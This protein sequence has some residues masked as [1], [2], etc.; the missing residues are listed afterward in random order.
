MW[1]TQW[2]RSFVVESRDWFGDLSAREARFIAACLKGGEGMNASHVATGGITA[3]LATV[4]VYLSHWPPQPLDLSTA[5]AFAGLLV[6]AGAGLVKLYKS[7]TAPTG[8]LVVP[9]PPM[10]SAAP[11]SVVRKPHTAGHDESIVLARG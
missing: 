4:L 7:K 10:V 2:R 6:A 8:R 3:L 1:S 11:S 5:S 9:D